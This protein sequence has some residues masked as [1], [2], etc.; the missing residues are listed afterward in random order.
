MKKLSIA[1]SLPLLAAFF[2]FNTLMAQTQVGAVAPEFNLKNINGEMVSMDSFSEATGYIV[3]F[4]CNH[5]PY[6]KLYEDRIIEINNE[7]APQGWPVIAIN[8][9]DAE[10]YPDDSYKEMKKRAKEK[11]FTFPYL[12]DETQEIAKAYGASKTPHVFLVA[13]NDGQRVVAYIGAIDDNAKDA[14]SVESNF[15]KDA[16]Q[17]V[18]SGTMPDPA[19]TK[20]VGCGIKW[21][22]S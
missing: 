14:G 6:S 11:G 13:N 12:H 22:K 15:L 19:E 18:Q 8:P 2:W 16:I 5:C 1:F 20:A 17:A 21:K 10:Q 9:N 3:I 4:T 7:F